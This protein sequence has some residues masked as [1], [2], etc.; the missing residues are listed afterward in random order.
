MRVIVLML[1]RFKKKFLRKEKHTSNLPTVI[2][3]I[4]PAPSSNGETF[5]KM[6]MHM[7]NFTEVDIVY[8]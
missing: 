5:A 7:L 1:D 3:V 2:C 6:Q 8:I 4:I